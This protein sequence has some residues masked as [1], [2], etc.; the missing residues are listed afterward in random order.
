MFY[1]KHRTFDDCTQ[2]SG[3]PTLSPAAHTHTLTLSKSR[4]LSIFNVFTSFLKKT[5]KSL[6]CKLDSFLANPCLEM[7][8]YDIEKW[9]KERNKPCVKKYS[10][11]FLWNML[12]YRTTSIIILSESEK[13]RRLVD[14]G[15]LCS[16]KE[17]KS[18]NQ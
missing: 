17:H 2:S 3:K 8:R 9:K 16:L 10:W 6:T 18:I 13:Q 1:L 11:K 7:S 15:I 14:R 5:L 12:S 4:I